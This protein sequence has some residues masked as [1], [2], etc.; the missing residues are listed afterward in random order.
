[1]PRDLRTNSLTDS[2]NEPDA[3]DLGHNQPEAAVWCALA[4]M[5][6]IVRLVSRRMRL[7]KWR[8]LELEDALAV[9]AVLGAT[10]VM[11]LMD[12]VE[13][14]F[15]APIPTFMG[16]DPEFVDTRL[17][18]T[19]LLVAAE[20]VQIFTIWITKVGMLLMYARLTELTNQRWQIYFT[21]TVVGIAFVVMEALFFG[22]WCRPFHEYWNLLPDNQQCSTM[23]HHY[24]F[25]LSANVSTDILIL[26]I[27]LPLLC[28]RSSHSFG[29]QRT[30]KVKI[31]LMVLL[32]MGVFTIAAA[33]AS[34]V[35]SF[36]YYSSMGF[37][38]WYIRE[39]FTAILCANLPRT[40]PVLR[41]IHGRV[42]RWRKARQNN[43]SDQKNAGS[44]P[45]SMEIPLHKYPQSKD[46]KATTS[47]GWTELDDL[48]ARIMAR[49]L[50]LTM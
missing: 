30:W 17:L 24:I 46:S 21:G 10:A 35:F 2:M 44:Q 48:E 23:K 25:S 3:P 7:G 14:Y 45:H 33:V 49:D 13:Q 22:F 32:S 11:I 15:P 26:L 16:Y 27:P 29:I 9:T 50:A 39:T 31:P 5:V 43:S 28:R 41:W 12:G 19:K 38:K 1:M 40:M 4:W 6:L 36:Q 18:G 20:Q 42:L 34:K 37:T 47:S 8:C